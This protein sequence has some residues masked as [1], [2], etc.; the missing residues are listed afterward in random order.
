VSE[1]DKG[2]VKFASSHDLRRSFG[3]RWSKRIMP[4]DLMRLMRH[5]TIETTMKF[6]VGQNARSTAAVLSEATGRKS[7][8][9]DAVGNRETDPESSVGDHLGDPTQKGAES[10]SQTA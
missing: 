1:S 3:E 4:P 10:N 8:G 5:E 7:S 2:K 9:A 6:Y